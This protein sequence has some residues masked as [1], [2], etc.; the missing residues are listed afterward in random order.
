MPSPPMS[1]KI[2]SEYQ[3]QA[4]AQPTADT[5]YSTPKI[6]RI[7]LRPTHSAGLPEISEPIMVPISARPR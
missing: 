4:M 2:N 3:S 6:L 5:R 7:G 1:R